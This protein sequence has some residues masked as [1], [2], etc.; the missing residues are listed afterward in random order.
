[1]YNTH[2]CLVLSLFRAL[3]LGNI[4]VSAHKLSATGSGYYAI[5][6]MK[7]GAEWRGRGLE[8]EKRR[9]EES[10]AERERAEHRWTRE[11]IKMRVLVHS[12]KMRGE[13]VKKK[14]STTRGGG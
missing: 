2:T 6:V 1:M 5:S 9:R 4:D 8:R 7:L 12:M 14:W 10:S 3:C 11:I 13:G